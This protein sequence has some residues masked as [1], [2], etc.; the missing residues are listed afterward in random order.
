MRPDHE[1]AQTDLPEL[2]PD[3]DRAALAATLRRDGRVQV[4]NVLTDAAAA[5]MER[6]LTQET[7]WSFTWFDGEAA[8]IIDHDRMKEVSREEWAALQKKLFA[9]ARKDFTYACFLYPMQEAMRLGRD[10]GL[11]IHD[12]FRFLNGPEMMTLIRELLDDPTVSTAD[13]QASRFGPSNFL[14]W[15]NDLVPD[16][17]RRCAYVFNFTRTWLPDWGGYLQFY[18][19]RGNGTAAFRPDFNTL[20]IFTVPQPHS[21]TFVPPFAGGWRYAVSGWYRAPGKAG[22]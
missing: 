4:H 3:L 16:A 8:C 12:F 2:S 1:N 6:C 21:V 20:N 10:P 19:A 22:D 11:Y 15:H 13:A 5:R 9:L 7:P 18:D 17:N 14:S